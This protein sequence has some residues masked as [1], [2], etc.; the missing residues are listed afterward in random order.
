MARL[1]GPQLSPK[2]LS[3]MKSDMGKKSR[4]VKVA[5]VS[6][7]WRTAACKVVALR[8]MGLLG[9]YFLPTTCEPSC[10]AS[11]SSYP[12]SS[13]SI[14]SDPDSEQEEL[15]APSHSAAAAAAAVAAS[16]LEEL[17]LCS[18]RKPQLK[19]YPL[20]KRK[21]CAADLDYQTPAQIAK[22][23]AELAEKTV[24]QGAELPAQQGKGESKHT[25]QQGGVLSIKLLDL[26]GDADSDAA[27][28]SDESEEQDTGVISYNSDKEWQ[29][30]RA[31]PVVSMSQGMGGWIFV[32]MLQAK[33]YATSFFIGPTVPTH[34]HTPTHQNL[35]TGTRDALQRLK[36][37]LA[38]LWRSRD[39]PDSEES[40]EAY[41]CLQK[42][43]D[44]LR[45]ALG[46][47]LRVRSA[48]VA[49]E[50]SAVPQKVVA[51][52]QDTSAAALADGCKNVVAQ[53]DGAMYSAKL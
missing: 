34:P 50:V 39:E 19:P 47:P 18:N 36:A 22:M 32:K 48:A 51:V 24:E 14:P 41:Q 46:T 17:R 37:A 10:T 29:L 5:L 35:K 26:L 8:R 33:V 42:A 20:K 7:R 30:P 12:S 43:M 45:S 44:D 15:Q 28:N 11:A 53:K 13:L 25:S 52:A 40:K 31:G 27:D 23:E 4:K 2:Q 38:A 9:L 21:A 1:F 3:S 49:Q 6:R 16:N